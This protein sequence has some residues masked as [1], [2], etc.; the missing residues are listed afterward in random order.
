MARFFG[1]DEVRTVATASIATLFTV[2][3]F[4]SAISANATG[5]VA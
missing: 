2:V 1:L 4:L 3:M 5:V